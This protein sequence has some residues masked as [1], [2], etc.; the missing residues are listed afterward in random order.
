M[1]ELILKIKDLWCKDRDLK[2][3]RRGQGKEGFVKESLKQVFNLV[4]NNDDKIK[5]ETFPNQQGTGQKNKATDF[6][7]YSIDKLIIPLE[8]EKWTIL[9][10]EQFKFLINA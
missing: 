5:P 7:I 3:K 2:A 10:L 1:N 8:V 9:K 4:K 6:I